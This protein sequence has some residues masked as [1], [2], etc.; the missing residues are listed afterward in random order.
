MTEIDVDHQIN[1]VR[2]T[3]RTRVLE[4]G[5]AKV[6]TVSQVS[7]DPTICGTRARTSSIPRWFRRSA[8]VARRW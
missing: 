4:A 2:R 3:V 6:V 7:D 1:A 8:A 5:E